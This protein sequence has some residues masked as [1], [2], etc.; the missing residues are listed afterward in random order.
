MA[1]SPA[2]ASVDVPGVD[3]PDRPVGTGRGVAERCRRGGGPGRASNGLT[4]RYVPRN[5]PVTGDAVTTPL[6]AGAVPALLGVVL[7]LL[8]RRRRHVGQVD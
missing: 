4:F 7:V 6:A 5:L 2:T 8:T 1:V 3:G